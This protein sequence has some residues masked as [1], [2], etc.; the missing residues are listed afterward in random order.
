MVG[1]LDRTWRP[2]STLGP[3]IS[4]WLSK[5]LFFRVFVNYLLSFEVPNHYPQH[6]LLSLAE[7]GI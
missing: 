2:K 7:D 6:S 5:H 4:A 1:E 3:I